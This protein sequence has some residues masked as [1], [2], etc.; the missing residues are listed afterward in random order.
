MP[1]TGKVKAKT[2]R[3]KA[4]AVRRYLRAGRDA[5]R[6]CRTCG[7]PAAVSKRTGRVAKQCEIHLKC[8]I[9]RKM[10]YLLA[11]EDGPPNGKSLESRLVYPLDRMI[12]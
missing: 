2:E 1:E 9:G 3:R 4:A 6:Q 8:D 7:E 11:V 5:K 12:R 10:I